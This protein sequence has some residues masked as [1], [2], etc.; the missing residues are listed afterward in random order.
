MLYFSWAFPVGSSLEPGHPYVGFNGLMLGSIYAEMGRN[1]D[2]DR[3]F[4]VTHA[5]FS[6]R[7]ADDNVRAEFT[8]QYAAFLR[9]TGR[10]AEAESLEAEL[11]P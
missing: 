7:P 5:I 10:D 9:A 1:D 3:H 2:A 8:A 11:R 6:K 4:K